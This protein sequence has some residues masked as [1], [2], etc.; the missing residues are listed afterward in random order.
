MFHH[1]ALVA[2]PYDELN[3]HLE[4]DTLA[5]TQLRHDW[6]VSDPRAWQRCSPLSSRRIAIVEALACGTPVVSTD[7][8]SSPSEMLG[9]G[10]YRRLVPVGDAAAQVISHRMLPLSSILN[11]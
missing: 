10:R 5:T 9:N 8:P 6:Q 7:C 11:S 3:A 1:V 2:G 4:E